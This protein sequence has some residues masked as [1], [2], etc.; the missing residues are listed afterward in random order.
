M[1]RLA[2]QS[3]HC[4]ISVCALVMGGT[5]KFPNSSFQSCWCSDLQRG[6]LKSTHATDCNGRSVRKSVLEKSPVCLGPRESAI[7]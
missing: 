2:E 3:A 6:R 7:D 4:Y 5:A 1:D